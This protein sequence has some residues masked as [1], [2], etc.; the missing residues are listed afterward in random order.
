MV[1]SS[2]LSVSFPSSSRL[3]VCPAVQ[4]SSSSSAWPTFNVSSK[5]SSDG[6]PPNRTIADSKRPKEETTGRGG[7]T[8]PSPSCLR[9]LH[10]AFSYFPDAQQE[11]VDP[12]A[13]GTMAQWIRSSP[14]PQ[15][16]RNMKDGRQHV[17]EKVGVVESFSLK[18]EVESIRRAPCHVLSCSPLGRIRRGERD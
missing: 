8:R 18:G 16:K 15:T 9:I 3:G 1:S 17:V 2:P 14:C 7:K 6:C 4:L 11:D 10:F 5:T 12:M 13:H